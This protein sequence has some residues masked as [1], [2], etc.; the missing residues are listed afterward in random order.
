M[1]GE[2]LFY[3]KKNAA[4]ILGISE[5]TLHALIVEKQLRV[6]RIGRRVVIHR[7]ALQEF[8][9]RDHPTHAGQRSA[10][11]KDGRRDHR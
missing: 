10:L 5:R 2:V 11:R 3:S 6:R 1:N 7:R 4:R 9:R 8:A